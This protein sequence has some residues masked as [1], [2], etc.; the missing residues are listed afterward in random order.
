ML[1]LQHLNPSQVIVMAESSW[2]HLRHSSGECRPCAF[3]G[4]G[5][6][7]PWVDRF[8]LAKW[9]WR[10]FQEHM[11]SDAFNIFQPFRWQYLVAWCC[12][13][14]LNV[15][16]QKIEVA[17][18]GLAAREWH[19]C[20]GFPRVGCWA[21][22][23]L[24]DSLEL[25]DAV[26][27][28]WCDLWMVSWGSHGNPWAKPLGYPTKNTN[29]GWIKKKSMKMFNDFRFSKHSFDSFMMDLG[30]MG[31]SFSFWAPWIG[32]MWVRSHG[33]PRFCHFP[34]NVRR[35]VRLG[36]RKRCRVGKRAVLRH[37]TIEWYLKNPKVLKRDT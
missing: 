37:D 29:F 28:L 13:V 22:G 31:G 27:W 18:V 5:S 6:L 26:W 10:N 24:L 11:N 25:D 8:G 12:V 16:K 17:S 33:S 3:L 4:Q 36:R 34:H 21:V 1:H 35:K 32:W 20:Q 14:F 15:A 30:I 9:S 2:L 19:V 7:S 23:I